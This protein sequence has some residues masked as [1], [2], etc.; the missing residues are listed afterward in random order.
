MDEGI[1]TSGNGLAFGPFRLFP[2]AR[3]LTRDGKALDIG[4]R[5]FDLLVVL[6]EQPGRVVSKRELLKRVWSD[7]VV[8]D[9]SLRFHLAGLRKTLGDGEN[10]LRLIATQVGV[11]YAFVAPITAIGGDDAPSDVRAAGEPEA[12]SRPSRPK[13]FPPRATRLVGREQD[14]ALLV[15]RLPETPLFS[16]VGP[17]GVGKTS[18]AVELGHRLAP[19]FEERLAFVDFSM[20][21][22]AEVVPAMIA[23]A[24]GIP[25]QSDD[26][27]AVILGHLRDHRFL[28]VLD[29]CEH[30]IEAAAAIVERL[31]DEA[32]G[33]R[34]LATSREPLRVKDE[35]VHRLNA[36]AYPDDVAD[37]SLPELLAYPAVELFCA[38][39]SA[40]DSKFVVDE[41]AARLIG[42]MCHRL[43]GMALPIELAAVRVA[44]HGLSATAAQLGERFNLSWPGRRTAQP[45][46]QT[47]Q[48]TLDWSYG[49][50]TPNEQIVLERLSVF[51]GPFSLD[52]ALDVAADE[53]IGSNDVVSALDELIAKSLVSPN[54]SAQQG[55]YRLLEMTRAY[56]R[57]KLAARGG[58]CADCVAHRHARYFLTELE[59]I[60]SREEAE[61]LDTGALRLQLGNIRSALD[62]SFGPR[63]DLRLGVRLAAA[64][65]PIF[66]NLSHL[67]ECRAWC[68]RALEQIE[69]RDRGAV[70]E[71]ELQGALGIS[72]MFTDGNSPA[73]GSALGRALDIALSLGDRWNQLRMLGGLHIFHERIGEYETAMAYAQR[74]VAVAETIGDDEARG[75]AYS[76]SGIS[77]HLA[78]DQRRALEDLQFSLAKSLASH[79]GR[80]I[81]YGFDHKNRSAIAL[82]RALWLA[83]ETGRA[84]SV[85]RHSVRDASHLDHPATRCIALIWALDVYIWAGDIGAAEEALAAF[86]ACA[87]VNAFSPYIAAADGYR[88]AIE[89][90][91][92]RPTDEALELVSRSLTRLHA[93]RYEL[94]T[95]LFSI[96]LVRG[97]ASRERFDEARML[98]DATIARCEA[99]GEHFAYPELLRLKATILRHADGDLPGGEQVLDEARRLAQRQGAQAWLSLIETDRAAHASI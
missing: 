84:E 1:Q 66:Q 55:I 53:M 13:N 45:R 6:T 27:L 78:G 48:A 26:P 9:G 39:A 8:E 24:M 23:G 37:L 77:R 5:S 96:T 30:V 29:N 60:A 95:T 62:W 25:V 16:V 3:L 82:A 11:G 42:G 68:R 67:L 73:V 98:V 75:V 44:T 49:L 2:A 15:E 89:I 18:L 47:L 56:A 99:S 63:G 83:G 33:V 31:V 90:E 72:S 87:E 19:R 85:A 7:V 21:E 94:L 36:L 12:T 59:A 43:D 38:R 51:V 52:A 57:Q 81:R 88:G 70:L 74:A 50:L 61:L 97:L 64:S 92:G 46:Q 76:L 28:L 40:A 35:N 32:P 54:R 79:R 58:G 71:M 86:A 20:L 41:E 17:A 93:T 4:G 91:R 22:N 34:I 65:A 80:T 14:I 10:G 69:E